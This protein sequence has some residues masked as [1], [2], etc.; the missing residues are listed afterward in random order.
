MPVASAMMFAS[1]ARAD[2]AMISTISECL[3]PMLPEL[4]EIVCQRGSAGART[5]DREENHILQLE[6]GDRK[7][8]RTSR[9][10]VSTLTPSFRQ[11][12][13]CAGRAV[14]AL[15]VVGD[16]YENRLLRPARNLASDEHIAD[17]LPRSAC[18]RRRVA[19][20]HDKVGRTRKVHLRVEFHVNRLRLLRGV[21]CCQRRYVRHFQIEVR[22]SEAHDVGRRRA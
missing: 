22:G 14:A 15:A 3:T 13:T 4:V 1:T 7:I 19:L 17:R 8:S 10:I 18:R 6:V 11:H 20:R 5:L 2:I 21:F 12:A 16:G 9:S